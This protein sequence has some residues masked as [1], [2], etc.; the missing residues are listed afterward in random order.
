MRY[1]QA[2]MEAIEGILLDK[3]GNPLPRHESAAPR[4]RVF[5][6]SPLMGPLF[7]GA[8][9]LLALVAGL[10]IV[11]IAVAAFVGIFLFR[12]LFGI[13]AGWGKPPRAARLRRG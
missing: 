9:V 2:Q 11:G 10:T 6:L 1:E 3:E 7:G 13:L 12:L 4:V 5:S 8:V